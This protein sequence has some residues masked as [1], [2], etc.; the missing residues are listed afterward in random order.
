MASKDVVLA[1]SE[2]ISSFMEENKFEL[3]DVE[4]V[5]EGPNW[6][7]RIF[8]DKDGGITLD[9]CEFISRNIEVLLDKKD[10]IE[11]AY[12]LEVSSPGID[13]P[14]KKESDYEKY[15][16]E[17]IDIKLYKA[18]DKCKEFQ[19]VLIGL[20]DSIVAIEDEN[21]KELSFSLADIASCR[22]AVI[23]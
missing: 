18:V 6:Y 3:C 15:A 17:I 13:R 21:G 9:D 2:I 12:I 23:F 19:G 4:F 8:A 5:K 11:Q 1:V 20:K 7:L 14:L 22:L 16:G 10:P